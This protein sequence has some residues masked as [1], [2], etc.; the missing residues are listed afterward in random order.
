MR[1]ARDRGAKTQTWRREWVVWGVCALGFQ[2][3]QRTKG[4]KTQTL[5]G[6]YGWFGKSCFGLPTTKGVKTQTLGGTH[7]RRHRPRQDA[8][9]E[10]RFAK[11][12]TLG[13]ECGW[14]GK[15]CF[16][17]PT[18]SAPIHGREQGGE[19]V[20]NATCLACWPQGTPG[21]LLGVGAVRTANADD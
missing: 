3:G 9:R 21:I 5:R 1:G 11:T 2:L 13:G 7:G 14:F 18:K 10:K 6:E 12:Q 16:G 19:S 15:T 8:D 4:V 17:R 20:V